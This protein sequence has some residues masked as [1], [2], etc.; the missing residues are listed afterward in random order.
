MKA[1]KKVTSSLLAAMVCCGIVLPTVGCTPQGEQ[2]KIDDTKTQ[3]YISSYD[4]GIGR[5]WLE[6]TIT[7]FTEAVAEYSFEEGRK[8]VQV[9]PP[10]YNRNDSGDVLYE[11]I[12]SANVNL[13]FTEGIEYL[14]FANNGKMYDITKEV[15]QQGA[16]TGVDANGEFIREE[17]TIEAKIDGNFLN[18]LNTTDDGSGTSYFAVPYYLANKGLIY[19]RDL[20][21][22][23]K[24]YF[25]KNGCPS[26][27]IVAAAG[28]ASKLE[29]AKTQYQTLMS[30]NL[31]WVW[32]AMVGA[33]GEKSAGPDG[34]Y[35][36]ID[37]GLP[38]TYEEFYALMDKMAGSNITPFIWTGKNAGYADSLTTAL[39]QNDAGVEEL[40]V[41]YSLKGTMDELVVIE[42]GKIKK[43]NGQIVTEPKTFDGSGN[44]GYDVQR[45]ISK[46]NAL[47]FV[48]KIANTSAWTHEY[49]YN[50]EKSQ[51]AAQSKYL[52]SVT[53][54]NGEQRIAML[55]DGAWW[56]QESD[57]TFSIMTR[58]DA[59]Y[60]KENRD[61]SM[62]S[63]PNSDVERFCERIEN[64]EKMTVVSQNESY[65]FIN[66]NL[67][68]DS[69]Q[70]KAAI[71]FLSFMNSDKGLEIFTDA[72]CMLR[73]V[74]TT[75]TDEQMAGFSK[76]T[77]NVIEYLDSANVVYPYSETP[78]VLKNQGS[79]DNMSDGWNWRSIVSGKGEWYFPLTSLHSE[80]NK[81]KG[82]N[83]EVYFE[84]MYANYSGPF[85]RGLQK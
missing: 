62:F 79:F 54:P 47:N 9:M 24:F 5:T 4:A 31:D 11:K 61:F 65:C 63:L 18:F 68:K 51:V 84:G 50:T 41:Y 3:L 19:D 32:K 44:E 34:Q 85:W 38:A 67:G 52:M 6:N 49:G 48:N 36:T 25:G 12:A 70:L 56:Q 46:L 58:Q 42:D 72:A 21:D 35:G 20:W 27:V 14:K 33:N 75:F 40:G 28:D 15:M 64:K 16:I 57:Q 39:W 8:G 1:V 82:L 76:Y 43:Q 71:A 69:P 83:P 78:F 29:T 22:E 23:Q 59:K 30:G 26:E 66:G 80:E 17:K 74:R 2:V 55:M 10:D 45:S 73:P 53:K 60:S 13:Y 81:K 77:R 37:D 7:A